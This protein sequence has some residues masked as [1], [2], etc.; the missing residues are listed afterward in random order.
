MHFILRSALA[1]LCASVCCLASLT[2]EAEPIIT[3]RGAGPSAKID[4]MDWSNWRGPEQNRISREKGLVDKFDPY[5]EK[6]VNVLWKSTEAGGISTPIVMNGKLYTTCRHKPDTKVEQE[7]VICLEAATGK[8]IWETPFNVYL[9]D[10]PAERVGWASCVGDPTTGRVYVQGVCGYFAC[11]DGETGKTI[12]SRS[13][14]EEFGCVTTYGGR[15]NFPVIFDDMVIA[16]AVMTNWGDYAV[17]AHRFLAMDKAT[18]EVRWLNG[19]RVRPMDTTYSTPTLTT[20]NGEAAM[21]FGSSDGA[22][23]AFQPRTGKEIWKYQLSRRGLNVAPVVDGTRIYTAHN[24]E[25]TD[26]TSMGAI[27]AIDGSKTG[28]VTTSGELWKVKNIA[29]GKGAPVVI[30]GRVYI[31]DD[32]AKFYVFDAATGKQIGQK[33]SLTGTIVRGSPLYADGKLYVCTTSAWHVFQVTPKAAQPVNKLD[34]LRLESADEVTGS[35]IVSH[36]RIY[37]PTN[38]NLYCIGDPN[39]KPSADPIPEQPKETPVGKDDKA[40]ALQIVPGEMLLKPGQKQKLSVRLFNER[41]ELLDANAKDVKFSL[42]G[43]GEIANDTYAAASTPDHTATILTAELNGVKGTARF[44]VVPPLPWKFDFA[45]D[46]SRSSAASDPTKIVGE[47]PITWVGAR[48]RHVIRELDGEK[49]LVKVTTI[50]KGTRSQSWMGPIDLHDYTI[51]AEVRSSIDN[52][53]M[54]DMGLIAQR[55]TLDMMGANQKL[56]IRTWT[57]QIATRFSKD[58]AF[59]WKPNTWYTMKFKAS[60]VDGGAKA[61]LQGKV[62]PK[63]EPEPKAWTIEA[64]DDMPNVTGSPGLFGNATDAEVY[65]NH[66]SVTP[67]ESAAE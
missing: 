34:S 53:K 36:G 17:P 49:V 58:V 18:G 28:D 29:D 4:P 15:T 66:I 13:L 51:Q 41:G 52:G 6:P 43:P 20:F 8:K 55:Y 57:S 42:Q 5:A 24:E 32:T 37:L 3:I 44:R 50:P 12:W 48:Y 9:S 16:S 22:V 30:D 1:V 33:I 60:V 7:K 62:W 21:V 40:T 39:Q 45:T 11:L 46:S 38:S 54:P 61:L 31:T 63:G 10:V 67:N 2:A 26:N 27:V 59:P 56:Q 23:H 14:H 25:N 64:T 47:V 65:Y 19:T 35:P